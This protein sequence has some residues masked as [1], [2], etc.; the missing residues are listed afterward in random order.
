MLYFIYTSLP[1]IS[2]SMHTYKLFLLLCLY[3]IWRRLKLKGASIP[4]KFINPKWP[5]FCKSKDFPL[6]RNPW[7]KGVKLVHK[8]IT[9]YTVY[10]VI[11]NKCLRTLPW[12]TSSSFN[13]VNGFRRMAASLFV[14]H[15][16]Q[17][18]ITYMVRTFHSEANDTARYNNP[19]ISFFAL[20]NNYWQWKQKKC[21]F[22]EMK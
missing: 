8:Q 2:H 10:V 14:I 22:L 20:N 11:K 17:V 16:K 18:C 3:T 4:E 13:V 7:E 12:D 19:H 21:D 5:I 1:V 9:L 15:T 6:N